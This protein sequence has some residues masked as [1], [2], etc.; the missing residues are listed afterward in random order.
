[1]IKISRDFKGR[2]GGVAL[3][4]NSVPKNFSIANQP[5]SL[6]KLIHSLLVNVDIPIPK[7]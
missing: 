1:L 6:Q 2:Y 4:L 7:D 5:D 3:W